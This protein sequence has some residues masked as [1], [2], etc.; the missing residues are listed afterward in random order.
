MHILAGRFRGLKL[1]SP[2]GE[3]ARPTLSR[4]RQ[5]LFNILAP[6]LA[7]SDFLDVYAGSGS[8]GLEAFSQG[9]RSVVLVEAHPAVGKTLKQN[10]L[11][12]DP[13]QKQIEVI[14]TDAHHAVERLLREARLFD[15]VFLDP[16][17]GVSTILEWEQGDLLKR[18]LKPEGQMIFQ[19]SRHDA[20]PELLGGCRQVKQR[21]YGETTLSFYSPAVGPSTSQ[22]GNPK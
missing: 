17:Y 6:Y 20:A 15:L 19:H 11:R 18:L 21:A 22:E 14:A 2:P 1:Q 8:I 13:T 9:S 4:I 16:P 12:L 5:A 7:D 10:A 3:A